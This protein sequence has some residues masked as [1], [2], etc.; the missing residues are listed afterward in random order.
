MKRANGIVY[1]CQSC[2]LFCESTGA[3]V[4]PKHISAFHQRQAGAP[5]AVTAYFA[6]RTD[7]KLALAN[8]APTFALRR[9]VPDILEFFLPQISGCL[10]QLHAGKHITVR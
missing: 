4:S 6:L 3:L 8:T 1:T 5:F 10:G 2:F 7:G 9:V